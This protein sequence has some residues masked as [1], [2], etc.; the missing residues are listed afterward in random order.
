MSGVA[1]AGATA[2][3]RGLGTAGAGLAGAA[4]GAGRAWGS[5]LRV[6]KVWVAFGFGSGD[7][8][9]QL[10]A[11][12]SSSRWTPSTSMHSAAR[13]AHEGEVAAKRRGFMRGLP[14]TLLLCRLDV[15]AWGG[16]KISDGKTA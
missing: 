3:L 9:S 11:A 6:A 14:G 5:M 2:A 10:G 4:T 15:T 12:F 13:T 16:T 7:R 1:S 8:P